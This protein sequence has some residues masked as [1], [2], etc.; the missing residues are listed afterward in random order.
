LL[1]FIPFFRARIAAPWGIS[2]ALIGVFFV[3][4]VPL[5]RNDV[6][7][8]IPVMGMYWRDPQVAEAKDEE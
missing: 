8:K 1:T 6:L 7:A 2:A 4:R 5:I 3:D